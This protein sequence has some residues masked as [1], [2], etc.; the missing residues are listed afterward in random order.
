MGSSSKKVTVGYKYRM[1]LHLIFCHGPID[2]VTKIEM[3]GKT[4]WSGNSTGGSISISAEDLFGGEEKEGGVSGTV[5]LEMGLTT[6]PPNSYLQSKLG[7]SIPAF[8]GVVGM[9]LRQ[10]YIGMSPYLRRWDIW[11]SRI[12]TRQD[13]IAQWY[14]AKAEVQGDMNA[15]H[16]IRECLT[17]TQW[18]MG[19][20]ETDIDDASFQ[21]A[22][23]QMFTEGMGLSL[24]WDK[25][26]Q[27]DD[28][29]GQVLKHIDGSLYVHR[30][31][32]KFVLKLARGGYSVES[33][34][35]LNEDNVL[36]VSDFKRGT[37]GE[38]TNSVTVVY[39][40]YNTGKQGS[41]TVQDI[42]LVAQQ[43]AT[44]GTTVQYPGIT[45]GDLAT[46]LASRDLK[47]MSTPL[48]SATLYANRE[49]SSLN[50]GDLFVLSWPRYGVTQIVMRVM[51]V[52]LGNLTSNQVKITAIED[53]FALGQA[54]YAAPPPSEW[55]DPISLPAP[56][57]YHLTF[58][59]PFWE[60]VQRMGET[61]ARALDATSGFAMIAGVRPSSDAT[62]ARL[63]TNPGG[64]GYQ[65]PSVVDFCPTALLD[66]NITPAQTS[67]AIAGVIDSEAIQTATYLQVGTEIMSL[68]S[69]T[70]TL[71]VVGRG[72]LDTVPVA[73]SIGTRIWFSDVYCETD[74]IEYS[75]GETARLKLLPTT[76]KGTLAIGS[77]PEQTLVIGA[78]PAKPY[79]PAKLRLNST[80]Y[81]ASILGTVDL[82]VTWVHRDRL[83]QTVSLVDT[84]A[85]SIGPEAG[86]TYTIELRTAG[87]T[88]ISTATGLTGL[89][90]TFTLAVMGANYGSLRVLLW[91]VRGGLASLQKHD[92]TFTRNTP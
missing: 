47:V 71:L 4:A 1:G 6:Q 86:T 10:V 26:T 21:A 58:E 18:G 89:T 22:A 70:D 35:Q 60:L 14:D 41:V 56:C 27:L 43:G 32:G 77:A 80:A 91:S 30:T 23:D 74:N 7:S 55:T 87:G 16:I 31:T 82:V 5:D 62:D 76:S 33:L 52:E 24:L 61:E 20:P 17:D 51:S 79:P 44:N 81:P 19:Y 45:R 48:A 59:S 57:P 90:H 68:V 65:S 83:Q 49:A 84:E 46:Q 12:H 92:W 54:I 11:G 9:V 64:A 78:R 69:Y 25:G 29:I 66:A 73:H 85:G 37:I 40:D 34:L 67:I 88:L 72:V 36:K 8:R 63:M 13:G 39:W 2:K 53:A 50:I 38:L 3:D 15:A 28:F 75:S 42:A